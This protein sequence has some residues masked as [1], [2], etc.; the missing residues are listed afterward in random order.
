MSFPKHKKEEE[1]REFWDK[2]DSV[3]YVNYSSGK[4]VKFPNLKASTK[5]ISLRLP[6]SMIDNLKVIAN[7]K[8]IPYQ[9]LIKI[10]ISD[11]IEE[12]IKKVS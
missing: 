4:R 6:E 3:D 8:D 7:K 5:S 10:Y 2:N 9:S 1:V 12:E 11:K